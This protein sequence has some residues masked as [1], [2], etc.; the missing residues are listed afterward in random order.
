MEIYKN[1]LFHQWSKEECLSDKALI[2]AI[3]EMVNGIYDANLG[4]YIYKKRIAIRGKGKRGSLRTII[5][6]KAEDKAI[7][8]Y[9]YAKNNKSNVSVKE[10]L[11]LK[12]LAKIYFSYGV[13]EIKKAVQMNE[14]I[15]VYDE[16][17]NF[18]NSA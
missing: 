9:G 12:K 14:L 1:K 2:D 17:D 11:A 18:R 8:I 3:S 16:E 10:E 13:N 7:F 6:Y 4:G 5:A 15:E